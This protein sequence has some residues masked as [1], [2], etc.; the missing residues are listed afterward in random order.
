MALFLA[1]CVPHTNEGVPQKAGLSLDLPVDP[2]APVRRHVAQPVQT[3]PPPLGSGAGAREPG[4]SAKNWNA[5]VREL[6]VPARNASQ[7]AEAAGAGVSGPA[8]TGNKAKHAVHKKKAP[9]RKKAAM[10]KKS[11][12][13]KR[14]VVRK[15]PSHRKKP[16]PCPCEPRSQK[17]SAVKVG[18]KPAQKA[19]AAPPSP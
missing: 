5:P 7:L 13:K 3:E 17:K 8:V 12:A 11:A 6:G 4:V 2:S 15:R 1:A 10:K 19:T 18:P 14:A 16:A 9:V